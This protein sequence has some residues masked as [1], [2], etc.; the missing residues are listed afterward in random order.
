[1]TVIWN[2]E[3]NEAYNMLLKHPWLIDAKVYHD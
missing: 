3:V 2:K 1:L